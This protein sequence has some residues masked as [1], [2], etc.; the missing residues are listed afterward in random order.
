MRLS[1]IDMPAFKLNRVLVYDAVAKNQIG[2]YPTSSPIQTINQELKSFKT[3]R[4]AVQFLLSEKLPA[5]LIKSMVH[6]RI[7]EYKN[8]PNN[9]NQNQ[10]YDTLLKL[11]YSVIH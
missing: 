1:A 6:F 11:R 3:Y 10:Q 7:N 8:S 4:G 2:L 9:K 5:T